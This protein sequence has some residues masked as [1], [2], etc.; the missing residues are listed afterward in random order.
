MAINMLTA[1]TRRRNVDLTVFD[2]CNM[3]ITVKAR[4]LCHLICMRSLT[5]FNMIYAA[6]EI[7]RLCNIYRFKLYCSS[8]QV[9]YSS[10]SVKLFD[11]Y[12]TYVLT[13]D[14]KSV[15][16]LVI[17]FCDYGT[18]GVV[19]YFIYDVKVIQPFCDYKVMAS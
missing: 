14:Y 1:L 4:L 13:S 2:I 15:H 17:L 11:V 7:Q 16:M 5:P 10:Y 6:S 3:P 8:F 19:M 18:A 9:L 12:V